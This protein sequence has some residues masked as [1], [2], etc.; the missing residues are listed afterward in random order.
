MGHS[1]TFLQLIY[2]R[3]IKIS[4]LRAAALLYNIFF[5]AVEFLLNVKISQLSFLGVQ[6]ATADETAGQ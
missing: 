5:F 4:N 2:C 6:G 3:T 1:H